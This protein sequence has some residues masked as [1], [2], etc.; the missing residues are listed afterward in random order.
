MNKEISGKQKKEPS[1]EN[2]MSRGKQL[3]TSPVIRG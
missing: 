3:A 2:E 1:L